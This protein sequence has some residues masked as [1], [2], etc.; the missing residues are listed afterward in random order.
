MIARG[1]TLIEVV[2][3]VAIT[4][5]VVL[6]IGPLFGN[7]TT[8]VSRLD[9]ARTDLDQSMNA[10]RWSQEAFTAV[11]VGRPGDV[12]FLGNAHELRF[13]AWLP[14]ADGWPEQQVVHLTRKGPKVVA[15]VKLGMIALWPDVVRLDID[16]LLVPGETSRWEDRW[17]SPLAAPA[18]V[19]LRIG[20]GTSGESDTL[21][22]GV[23]RGE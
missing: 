23:R 18:A 3:A 5:V 8:I 14:T 9:R 17:E 1:F 4:G 22:F 15:E 16:Y 20:H 11:E 21:L 12:P 2:V 10:V 13:T 7:S 19:R 6:A